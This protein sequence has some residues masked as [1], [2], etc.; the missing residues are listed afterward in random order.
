[1]G[2]EQPWRGVNGR[3][4]AG[5][6]LYVQVRVMPVTFAG[7]IETECVAAMTQ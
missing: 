2:S 5:A 7:S 1:V 3:K 4:E 6:R